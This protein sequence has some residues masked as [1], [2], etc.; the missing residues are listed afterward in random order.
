M[1]ESVTG[2][3]VA[4]M[5]GES[6]VAIVGLFAARA[7]CDLGAVGEGLALGAVVVD[8]VVAAVLFAVPVAEAPDPAVVV[9]VDEV[10]AAA[11]IDTRLGRANAP[12]AASA[13]RAARRRR[14]RCRRVLLVGL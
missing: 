5:E 3:P 14:W 13:P 12:A 4:A 7:L 1:A 8:V 10:G 2:V 11:E 6:A 9:V